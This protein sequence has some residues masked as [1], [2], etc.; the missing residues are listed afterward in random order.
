MDLK[1]GDKVTTPYGAGIVLGVRDSDNA[2]LVQPTNWV[3][4]RGQKATFYMNPKDVKLV[5][6][7]DPPK[8]SYV[9]ECL[10]LAEKIKLEANDLFK[11]GDIAAAREKYLDAL[12][13]LRYLG[14]DLPNEMKAKKLEKYIPIS[15]NIALCS[16]KLKQYNDCKSYSDN[17]VRILDNLEKEDQMKRSQILAELLKLGL[18]KY[19]LFQDFRCKALYYFGKA[20]TQSWKLNLV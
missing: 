8:L 13:K 18:S 7:A 3:M 11:Q 6:A 1:E 16:M 20:C 4:D 14:E 2:V 12:M 15:N 5:P 9:E 10:L 19:K 17:V